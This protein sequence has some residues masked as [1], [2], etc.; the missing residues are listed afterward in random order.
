MRWKALFPNK[1]NGKT[2]FF[3]HPRPVDSPSAPSRSLIDATGAVFLADR[4]TVATVLQSCRNCRIFQ[5]VINFYV[6]IE[7]NLKNLQFLQF[8]QQNA[9]KALKQGVFSIAKPLQTGCK[10]AENGCKGAESAAFFQFIINFLYLS[11]FFTDCKKTAQLHKL[12]EKPHHV[13]V[14]RCAVFVQ[15][16]RKTAPTA[17]LFRHFHSQFLIHNASFFILHS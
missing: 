16:Q 6:S 4:P 13:W 2:Q 5:F 8:L 1:P 10:I 14:F 11:L 9:N 7:L 15:I 3:P 12:A 17:P